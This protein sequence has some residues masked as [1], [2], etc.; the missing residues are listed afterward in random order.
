MQSLPTCPHCGSSRLAHQ[1]FISNGQ[2]YLTPLECK[3][4]DSVRMEGVLAL[5]ASKGELEAGWI[6]GNKLK[7]VQM[8]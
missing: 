6:L 3:D 1:R 4:C 8:K 7:E 5:G 2:V